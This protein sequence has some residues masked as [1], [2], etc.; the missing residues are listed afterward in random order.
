MSTVEVVALSP[1][2]GDFQ[3][4]GTLCADAGAT[5]VASSTGIRDIREGPGLWRVGLG[6]GLLPQKMS[7]SFI[8]SVSPMTASSTASV[9]D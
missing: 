6:L 4:S 3:G 7:S 1:G 8:S 9:E 2:T 5:S